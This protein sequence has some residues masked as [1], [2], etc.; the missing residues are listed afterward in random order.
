MH[1]Y[2]HAYIW[3]RAF[4]GSRLI[5]ALHLALSLSLS[6]EWRGL[7]STRVCTCTAGCIC[8]T[9]KSPLLLLLLMCFFVVRTWRGERRR[10]ALFLGRIF[11]LFYIV[12]FFPV[13]I[14]ILCVYCGFIS[15]ERSCVRVAFSRRLCVRES[16]GE[17]SFGGGWALRIECVY[18]VS[19]HY[20]YCQRS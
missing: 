1:I 13:Y 10:G 16:Y 17:G 11:L 18:T 2:I 5:G 9:R 15:S 8:E 6:V 4:S 3:K 14:Y 19:F 20:N 7:S 12:F